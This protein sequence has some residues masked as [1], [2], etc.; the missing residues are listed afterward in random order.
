MLNSGYDIRE[1]PF[2][3]SIARSKIVANPIQING[4]K[5]SPAQFSW[6]TAYAFD[7]ISKY[8]SDVDYS[9]L[10]KGEAEYQQFLDELRKADPEAFEKK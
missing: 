4:R 8:Y 3:W 9:K 7:Y 5:Q 2:A 6:Y 1:A 10:K